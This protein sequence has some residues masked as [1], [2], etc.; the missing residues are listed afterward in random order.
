MTSE[1]ERIL[2]DSLQEPF[3]NNEVRGKYGI[4]FS[5]RHTMVCQY[6]SHAAAYKSDTEL[7][8]GEPI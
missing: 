5:L 8:R 6:S 7:V 1:A 2:G 3:V 4:Y